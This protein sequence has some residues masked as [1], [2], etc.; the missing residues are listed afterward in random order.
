M[1][2]KGGKSVLKKKVIFLAI[3][4]AAVIL[5]AALLYPKK[6]SRAGQEEDTAAALMKADRWDLV[7]FG[8]YE[9][10]GNPDNGPEPL[11]WCV[12]H[13][14]ETGE[15]GTDILLLSRYC[16][17]CRA[18]HAP[19]QDI[20]WEASA[21]RTYLN[22]PFCREAFDEEEQSLIRTTINENPGN[23]LLNIDGGPDT[24]DR[25]FL[26][27]ALEYSVYFHDEAERWL[28]GR[29]EAT[30]QAVQEGIY[31][32]GADPASRQYLREGEEGYTRWWL[33]SPGN[34]AY[35]AQF[36][37]E[38]G[39]VFEGGAAVDIDYIYGLRPAVW[40]RLK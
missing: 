10:D 14:E 5:A 21:V 31:V 39:E 13:K 26:L 1:F 33:R 15:G 35:S 37:E 11:E 23:D 24:E 16:I 30:R 17:S 3:T 4:A 38:D 32:A 9:Q 22:G 18:F 6:K 27:N 19:V 8:R 29:A 12:L 28:T 7:T 40:V 36:V 2:G 34:E 25:A 20:T